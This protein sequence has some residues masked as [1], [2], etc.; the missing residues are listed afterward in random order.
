[1]KNILFTCLAILVLTTAIGQSKVEWGSKFDIDTKSEQD[2]QLVMKDNYNYYLASVVNKDGMVAQNQVIIRKFDQKNQLVNTFTQNFPQADM[3]TLHFYKGSYEIAGDKFVVF[4]H[5]YSSK[6][7]KAQ[8]DKIVF[9]KKSGT[10]TTTTLFEY[11]ILSASKSGDLFVMRSENSKYIGIVFQKYSTKKDP[12]ESDCI[13]LDG[14]TLIEVWKKTISFPAETNTNQR[15]LTNSGRFAFIRTVKEVGYNNVLAMV[16]TNGIEN[17]DFGAAIKLQKT[18]AISIGTQDYLIAFNYPA[19]GIRRGDFGYLMLYDIQLGKM[20]QNN[21]IDGFNSIKDINEVVFR[22]VSVQNNEIQLFADCKFQGGTKPDPTF[23]NSSFTVPVYHFGHSCIIT[24]EMDG[25]FKKK[26]DL[27]ASETNAEYNDSFGL[28]NYHGDH[29]VN[30]GFNGG[31]FKLQA[32]NFNTRENKVYLNINSE[33]R[34]Y[35]YGEYI[36]QFFTYFQDSSKM[37]FAKRYSDGKMIFV[38]YADIKL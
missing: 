9:D 8:L 37:L 38:T 30:L 32:P 29:Y 7:K 33:F 16:D 19:K 18:I 35:Q 3:F 31:F 5:S 25:K 23:P 2:M 17:K 27:G 15:V 28:M 11:P 10:F 13:V 34:D 36:N 21:D 4:A 14:T 24:L 1:M 12:E 20:L 26:I 22:N 6:T